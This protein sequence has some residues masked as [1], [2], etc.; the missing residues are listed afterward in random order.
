MTGRSM[1]GRKH[2]W[3][4]AAQAGHLRIMDLLIKSG[5]CVLTADEDAVTALHWAV[6]SQHHAAV[7]L[8]IQ[9]RAD[10]NV[11]SVGNVHTRTFSATPLTLAVASGDVRMLEL[12]LQGGAT[13]VNTAATPAYVCGAVHADSMRSWTPLISAAEA[14]KD[15]QLTALLLRALAD[16]NL[17]IDGV[18]PLHQAAMT[19]NHLALDLLIQAGADCS[20]RCREFEDNKALALACIWGRPQVV[21]RLLP[22][23]DV[24]SRSESGMAPLDIVCSRN[25]VSLPAGTKLL[26]RTD[27]HLTCL[28][29]LLDA[30]AD[31]NAVCDEGRTALHATCF[32]GLTDCAR[33]LIKAGCDSSVEDCEGDTALHFAEAEGHTELTAELPDMI[34]VQR[35]K[36]RNQARKQRKETRNQKALQA[37]LL[38]PEPELEEVHQAELA[39]LGSVK[40]DSKQG[41][42]EEGHGSPPV[43]P[44]NC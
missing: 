28:E 1:T 23:V 11:E 7:R 20:L 40:G 31:P 22:F 16:P 44:V 38:E 2:D 34:R 12:L 21:K 33:L 27:S 4:V 18:S 35:K 43:S 10:P 32:F 24:N 15:P 13:N 25:H 8:L 29:M 36:Q 19:G 17:Q 30:R 26:P 37:G 39:E 41:T 9:A 14:F 3:A 42:E 6:Q 5:A